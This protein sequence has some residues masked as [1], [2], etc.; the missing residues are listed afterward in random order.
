MEWTYM[1][2]LKITIYQR[3]SAL[4]IVV[5]VSFPIFYL[6]RS[7]S[8]HIFIFAASTTVESDLEFSTDLVAFYAHFLPS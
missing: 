4:I 6:I 3:N 2:Y 5:H 8:F 7:I 1:I